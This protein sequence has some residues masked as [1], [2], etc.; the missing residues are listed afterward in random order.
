MSEPRDETG[1][2]MFSGLPRSI[3]ARYLPWNCAWCGHRNDH[4]GV[5]CDRCHHYGQPPSEPTGHRCFWGFRSRAG[6]CKN[7]AVRAV[8]TATTRGYYCEEH[9]R[10]AERVLAGAGR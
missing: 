2:P 1:Y 9:A 3:R 8:D 5:S 7:E 10:E 6:Q 4:F